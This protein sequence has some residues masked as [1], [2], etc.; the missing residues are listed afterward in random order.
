MASGLG[1]LLAF[2]AAD[3]FAFDANTLALIRLDRLV[4]FD[5]GSD[6][7]NH[8]TIGTGDEELRAVGDDDRDAY[9]Y[10]V[11]NRVG[12]AEGEVADVPLKGGLEADAFDQESLAVTLLN[13]FHHITDDGASGTKDRT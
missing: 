4:E 1:G 7:A 9:R 11:T 2:L 10:R 5:G 6:L 12:V 13:A 3:V 8:V